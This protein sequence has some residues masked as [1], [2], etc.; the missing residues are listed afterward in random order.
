MVAS[1]AAMAKTLGNPT[2]LEILRL[3][4]HRGTC[5]TGDVVAEIPLARSTISEHLRVLR[6]AG[7]VQNE[8]DGPRTH[9]C[10]N[11]SGLDALEASVSSLCGA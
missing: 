4:A 2:R 8:I 9:Y 10:I 3:L 1:T 5:M 7:L 11:Q 6:E